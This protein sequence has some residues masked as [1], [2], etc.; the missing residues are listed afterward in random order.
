L[1][2]NHVHQSKTFKAKIARIIYKSLRPLFKSLLKE[3]KG[4]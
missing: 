2:A 3:A 4:K 1:V